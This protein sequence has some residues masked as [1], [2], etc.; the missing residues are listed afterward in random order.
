MTE[1]VGDVEPY[2][3]GWNRGPMVKH[4][5]FGSVSGGWYLYISEAR[6]IFGVGVA[7]WSKFGTVKSG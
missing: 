3:P 1:N 7:I 6:Q 4:P 5:R 2:T